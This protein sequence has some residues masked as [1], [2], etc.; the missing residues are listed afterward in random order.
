MEVLFTG[1]TEILSKGFFD[2]FFEEYHN[3]VYCEKE[4]KHLEETG[5]T[6]FKGENE[7][8][9]VFVAGFRRSRLCI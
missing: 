3:V 8:G 9:C 1:K 4:A 5:I 7:Q 2:A 6:V